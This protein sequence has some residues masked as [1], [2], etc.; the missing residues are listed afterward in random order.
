M[1]PLDIFCVGFQAAADVLAPYPASVR[2]LLIQ[3]ENPV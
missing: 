3:L 1:W 2:N